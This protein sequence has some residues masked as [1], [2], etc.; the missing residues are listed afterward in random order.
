ML[1]LYDRI[2]FDDIDGGVWKQ[3]WNIEYKESQWSS[4]NKLRVF[5]V[6]HSHN[7]PGKSE[8]YVLCRWIIML[9]YTLKKMKDV[10]NK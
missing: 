2:M 3:G 8:G 6:P 7:D 1:S 10:F 4:Q 5:I 9:S